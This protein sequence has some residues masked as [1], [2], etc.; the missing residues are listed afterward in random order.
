MSDPELY[1]LDTRVTISTFKDPFDSSSSPK[2]STVSPSNL[3]TS[4]GK[5]STKNKHHKH[6]KP[7][8]DTKPEHLYEGVDADTIPLL[9][10]RRARSNTSAGS[11]YGSSR[12]SFL[13]RESGSINN[14]RGDGTEFHE[15]SLNKSDFCASLFLPSLS[16]QSSLPRGRHIF[17]DTRGSSN[18]VMESFVEKLYPDR[19][20]TIMLATWN[21]L[22]LLAGSAV[23]TMPFAVVIGGYFSLVFMLVMSLMADVTGVLLIDCL[24][25]ISPNSG[26]R[27]RVRKDF[28]DIGRSVWGRTGAFIVH[29]FLVVYLF[30]GDVLNMLL[31]SKSVYSLLHTCTKLSFVA[32]SCLFS[33][34]AYPTLF[35][36]RLTILAYISLLSIITIL[37]SIVALIFVFIHERDSWSHNYKDIPFLNIERFPLAAGIIMFSC[38]SHCVLPQVE[39]NLMDASNSSKVIHISYI[40]SVLINILIGI[41]GALTFGLKTE[42]L[43]T[44]NASRINEIIRTIIGVSSIGYSVLNYPLNMFIICETVDKIIHDTKVE[45]NKKYYYAWVALTRLVLFASTVGLALLIPYF[46]ILLSLRG[47]LIGTCLVFV[48][49]CYFHLKL[50]WQ[51]LS[52]FQKT[53]EISL[54][55]IGVVLGLCALYGTITSLVYAFETGVEL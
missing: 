51:L 10:G 49:P 54:L 13:A 4:K 32:L 3:S 12:L 53:V 26:T 38:I 23:F 44:L 5:P 9:A 45:Q 11:S 22:P 18:S 25:E 31:L 42:S 30:L 46:G 17:D 35:I 15:E 37:F 43:V 24:Y 39:G 55:V 50:K 19:R 47:C 36:K 33:I 34:L 14:L 41:F 28:A 48:F 27:K 52:W 29:S 20:G 2:N 21:L 1:C 7:K 8:K 40:T 16:F 6:R